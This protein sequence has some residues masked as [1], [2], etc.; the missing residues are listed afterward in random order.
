MAHLYKLRGVRQVA[1]TLLLAATVLF[2]TALAAPAPASAAV[3]SA[4][5]EYG[6]YTLSMYGPYSLRNNATGLCLVA[7]YAKV[8]TWECD[9]VGRQWY[10]I[11]DV[12]SGKDQL[13]NAATGL[14]LSQADYT[15]VWTIRCDVYDPG[16]LWGFD[17]TVWPCL[18]MQSANTG[19]YL[20]SDY[21]RNVYLYRWTQNQCWY[22]E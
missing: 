5:S 8:Y 17:W 6:P 14:C 18:Y 2:G 3:P 10:F 7:D 9:V 20:A 12:S 13:Y 16:Q 1:I 19:G 4:H 22:Q 11:Y 15:H 21:S